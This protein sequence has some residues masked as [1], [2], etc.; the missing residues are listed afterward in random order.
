[1]LR[2]PPTL[3]TCLLLL[4]ACN[5][6]F[7]LE[8]E[9]R[10]VPLAYAYI[11]ADDDRHFVRVQK[12]FLE[13]GGDATANAAI[14]DSLYYGPDEAAVFL[15]NTRTQATAL[16]ERVDGEAFG[17]EREA[18][19]FATDPNILYTVA[20]DA[21]DFQGGDAFRLR[22]E[23]AGTEMA[24]A[25]STILRPLRVV[26]PADQVR[27]GNYDRPLSVTFR[28]GED[29]AIY[30]VRIRYNLRELYPN[31]PERNRDRTLE[32]PV[33]KSF[34]ATTDQADGTSV[35]IQLEKEDFYRF[36]GENLEEDGEVVRRLIDFDLI[37]TAAGREVLERQLLA[38]ANAGITGAQALP[39][40]TNLTGG[41]G[42]ITSRRSATQTGITLDGTSRD[43][44][45]NGSHTRRLN[46]R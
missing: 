11:D 8:G 14:A 34:V 4:A 16:L 6:D 2:L 3:I 23:R 7:T 37:V 39:R 13:A 46:F 36:L 33:T 42:L 20:A 5:D 9:Y 24:S 40:Y 27:L 35:R 18:G 30:D 32:W 17:L 31:D 41:I 38:N 10:N 19:V 44:L 43:S 12:A 28:R 15:T 29:A 22:I 1:M 26:G 45:R 21:L 25:A